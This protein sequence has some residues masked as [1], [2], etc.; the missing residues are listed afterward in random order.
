MIEYSRIKHI[1]FTG[2]GGA[3]MSGIAEVLFNMGFVVTGS[4]LSAGDMVQ[5]LR[6]LGMTVHTGHRAENIVGAQVLVFSSAVHPDNPEVECAQAH[7]I[8]VIARAEMLAELMRMKYS[9]AVAG[10]HGKTTT[11]SMLATI[12]SAADLDPTYVV[13]GR[14]KIQGSGAKLGSSRYLVAEADESDGSFLKLFPTVAVLT[15]IENDHLDHYHTMARLK[16]A[17]ADFANKV[18]FYGAVMANLGCA[19]IR[20]ILPKISK[21]TVT[22]GFPAQADI[23]AKVQSSTALQNRYVLFAHNQ[24]IGPVTLGVGGRHNILNALGATAAALEIGVKVETIAASLASFTLPERRLQMLFQDDGR[25]VFDDYAHHPGEIKVTL[26]TLRS[27]GF[28][29]VI[30]VFQP[31]R[32]TRL[33]LL[34]AGFARVLTL[35]DQVLVAPLYAAGQA[36]I[37]AVSSEILADA[38]RAAGHRDVHY[39]ATMAEIKRHLHGQLA[40]GDALIFLSAGNLTVTAHEFAA[41]LREVRT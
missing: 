5:R 36:A 33:K 40:A 12:L 7:K 19:N 8:P 20:A 11:T 18:P 21:K 29:R 23:H 39:F 38:V 1:H 26:Q 14:L 24:E 28:R 9:L 10:T 16:Q 35:A 25:V 6:S 22:F 13:G 2:I 34:L 3:G 4:D 37:A 15:N 41:E 27:G 31:H 17:F 30:A 32:Y